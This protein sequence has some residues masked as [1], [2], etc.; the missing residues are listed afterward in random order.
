MVSKRHFRCHPSALAAALLLPRT[1][2]AAAL[3]PRPPF[4]HRAIPRPHLLHSRWPSSSPC[5]ASKLTRAVA[6]SVLHRIGRLPHR[7]SSAAACRPLP[8]P[9]CPTCLELPIILSCPGRPAPLPGR[10]FILL[11]SLSSRARFNLLVPNLPCLPPASSGCRRLP[12]P[13][14]PSSRACLCAAA[15]VPCPCVCCSCPWL[16]L[17]PV[18]FPD[19]FSVSSSSV[20]PCPRRCARV[21]PVPGAASPICSRSRC[22]FPDVFPIPP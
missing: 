5:P 21:F 19:A 7:P 22:R 18:R 3:L 20:S 16:L 10:V 17:L 2:L 1:E 14:S 12:A 9:P 6:S 8:L 15:A 4:H 13:A 11:P